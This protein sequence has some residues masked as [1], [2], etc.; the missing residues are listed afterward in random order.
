MAKVVSINVSAVTGVKKQPVQEG[1]FVV[2]YGIE[3]DAHGGKSPIKQV[4]FL[5]KESADKMRAEG[6]TLK[7]GDFA[8]NV[9]TEGIELY[10]LPVGTRLKIGNTLHEVS[11]IG[12][13]CHTGCAIKEATGYCIM[14]T[15]G[16]FTKIIEGGMIHIGD[17]ITVL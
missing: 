15:E 13:T 5:A 2:G 10:T 11:Q 6:L 7:H 9:T 1:N 14:P 8:E 4:S 3:G 17:E 12:K 16:I